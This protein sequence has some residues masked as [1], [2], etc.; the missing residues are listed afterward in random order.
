VTL[1]GEMT[2]V[3][4][5]TFSGLLPA[6]LEVPLVARAHVSALEVANEDVEKV[7]PALDAAKPQVLQPCP[8]RV[9]QVQEEIADDEVI[10]IHATTLVGK[11][12]VL[13]P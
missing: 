7:S 11:P 6:V 10:I 1:P 13:E 4:S 9:S 5:E 3:F 12:V 2:N 8:G